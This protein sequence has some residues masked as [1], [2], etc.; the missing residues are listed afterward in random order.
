MWP[1]SNG[2]SNVL[3]T[4]EINFFHEKYLLMKQGFWALFLLFQFSLKLLD[5]NN[6]KKQPTQREAIDYIHLLEE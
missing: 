5:L 2:S 4:A 6:T 3:Y 1:W